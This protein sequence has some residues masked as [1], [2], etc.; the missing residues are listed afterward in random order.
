MNPGVDFVPQ[1]DIF[2]WTDTPSK[3]HPSR[4]SGNS[5]R[6]SGQIPKVESDF[7]V[8][9][10]FAARDSVEDVDIVYKTR[11]EFIGRRQIEPGSTPVAPSIRLD[12]S[13]YI[14]DSSALALELCSDLRF[15]HEE[16]KN[17]HNFDPA[18]YFIDYQTYV[19]PDI[20]NLKLTV[21][22]ELADGT[23]MKQESYQFPI[24]SGRGSFWTQ[25][26]FPDSSPVVSDRDT[27]ISIQ[28]K[29]DTFYLIIGAKM[30]HP[31]GL[32]PRWNIWD[33]NMCY[34]PRPCNI[35]YTITYTNGEREMDSYNLSAAN[36]NLD[37]PTLI[38]LPPCTNAHHRQVQI[39]FYL[40]PTG[41]ESPRIGLQYILI[42]SRLL[43]MPRRGFRNRMREMLHRSR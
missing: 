8:E 26:R 19:Q 3:S 17:W 4:K 18:I 22:A 42:S 33:P 25:S 34:F 5:L 24:H 31:L 12:P 38:S 43:P 39:S 13:R 7:T 11:D 28:K 27:Y 21:T 9:E 41:Q 35:S 10:L 30:T 6:T 23:M 1:F 40:M 14:V 36:I 15:R 16:S 37:E 29:E 2:S 32:T 20:D